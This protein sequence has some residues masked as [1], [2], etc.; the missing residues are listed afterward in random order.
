MTQS[1]DSLPV[2]LI[3]TSQGCGHCKVLR[4]DEGWLLSPEK[5]RP[6]S[7]PRASAWNHAFMR[8]FL[9]GVDNPTQSNPQI[10]RVYN[11]DLPQ[12]RPS[13]VSTALDLHVFDWVEGVV[14]QTIYQPYHGNNENKKLITG[15][16]IRTPS[17]T[18][19]VKTEPFDKLI[20]TIIPPSCFNYFYYFPMYAFADASLWNRSLEDPTIPIFMKINGAPTNEKSPYGIIK[21]PKLIDTAQV[22]DV[23]SIPGLIKSRSP[24]FSLLPKKVESTDSEVS[25]KISIGDTTLQI[26]VVS[27]TSSSVDVSRPTGNLIP[28]RM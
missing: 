20:E 23:A 12:L 10:M 16:I 24:L 7:I 21:N 17:E 5:S 15:T 8:K 9:T 2:A 6:G 11:I 27:E 4:P 3:V 13:P 14:R 28:L 19:I 18:K 22:L 1:Q 25:N 26:P